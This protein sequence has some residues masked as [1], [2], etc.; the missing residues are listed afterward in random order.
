MT[1]NDRLKSEN[2]LFRAEN[3]ELRQKLEALEGSM[4]EKIAKVM[5]RLCIPLYGRIKELERE[6]ERKDEEIT[7]LK[8]QI[9]KDSYERLQK[10]NRNLKNC[11]NLRVHMTG[12]LTKARRS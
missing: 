6:N 3:R 11:L 9:N 12:C 5:E 10:Q 7:R 8:A 1:G 4:E 2:R